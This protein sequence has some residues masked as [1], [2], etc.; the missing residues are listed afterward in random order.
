MNGQCIVLGRDKSHIVKKN[1]DSNKKFFE[2]DTIKMHSYGHQLSSLRRLLLYSYETDF[3]YN[4][5]TFYCRNNE[6]GS[7]THFYVGVSQEKIKRAHIKSYT[8]RKILQTPHCFLRASVLL[9]LC[10]FHNNITS[11]RFSYL[12]DRTDYEIYDLTGRYSI[13]Y[14][15]NYHPFISS[16]H[17]YLQENPFSLFF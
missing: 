14:I 13:Y 2:I 17:Y 4:L 10:I 9:H 11:L 16:I 3:T 12:T 1:S 15:D 7:D 6:N 8:A 5:S